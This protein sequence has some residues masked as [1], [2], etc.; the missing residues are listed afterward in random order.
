MRNERKEIVIPVKV[1]MM[2]GIYIFLLMDSLSRVLM[3]NVFIEEK[4]KKCKKLKKKK[5]KVNDIMD[6]LPG[7]VLPGMVK[8]VQKAAKAHQKAVSKWMEISDSD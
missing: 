4:P 5:D 2:V 6:M 3:N 8:D 1:M 7:M